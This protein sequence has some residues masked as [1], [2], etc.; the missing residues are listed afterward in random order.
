VANAEFR[1]GDADTLPVENSSVDI[2]ISNGVFNLC[3]DKPK[4]LVEA[5]RVLRPGGRIL[6]ADILLED[7][8]TPDEVAPQGHLVGL[9]CR[10]RVGAVAP[11]YA[12]RCWIHRS[13]VPRLDRLSNI[14]LHPRRAGHGA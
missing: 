11:H 8:V 13:E 1:Q 3:F 7:G 12:G 10:C 5:F 4:V 6:M 9:N 14:L 2:V